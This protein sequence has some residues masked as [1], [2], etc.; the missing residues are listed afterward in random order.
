MNL[1]DIREVEAYIIEQAIARGIDPK[2][3][4][5]V[6]KSEGLKEGVWQSNIVKDGV[7]EPSYGAWQLYEG[8]GL[9]NK[10]KAKYGVSAS[11]PR[12]W[13]LQT[14]FALDEA[15]R[16]G[17]GPWYGSRAV[18]VAPFEGIRASRRPSVGPV[19]GLG[20]NASPEAAYSP[21]EA[22]YDPLSSISTPPVDAVEPS[23]G[24]QVVDQVKGIDWGSLGDLG[25]RGRGVQ[26]SGPPPKKAP[27]ELQ[28]MEY[29]RREGRYSP[30][31]ILKQLG[32]I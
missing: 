20:S 5:K 8:G 6:A 30:L 1:P 13:K 3:A 31:G 21:P 7:R 29:V 22:A 16:G 11:D 15:K 10:F 19:Q 32:L 12:T 24:Q 4:L 17:W 26:S 23:F 27:M 25:Y 18:G 2:V 28:P 9:G 14:D